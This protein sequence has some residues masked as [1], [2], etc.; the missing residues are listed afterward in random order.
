MLHSS[1]PQSRNLYAVPFSLILFEASSS[2]FIMADPWFDLVATY[3][4]FHL[5]E[6]LFLITSYQRWDYDRALGEA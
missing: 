4:F 1:L 3:S 2:W 5:S 6:D